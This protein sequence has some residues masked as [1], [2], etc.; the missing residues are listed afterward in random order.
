MIHS[1][2]L[3]ESDWF[4]KY[5][6]IANKIYNFNPLE[7]YKPTNPDEDFILPEDRD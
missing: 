4:V 2:E 7:N 3:K 6:E 1:G 5:Q